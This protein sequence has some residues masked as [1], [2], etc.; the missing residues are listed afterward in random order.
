MIKCDVKILKTLS[1]KVVVLIGHQTLIV[2]GVGAS[3]TLIISIGSCQIWFQ[4]RGEE[5]KGFNKGFSFSKI[6]MNTVVQVMNSSSNELDEFFESS[7][8]HEG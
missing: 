8:I 1:L 6:Q 5:S 2:T 7:L 4:I 3:A